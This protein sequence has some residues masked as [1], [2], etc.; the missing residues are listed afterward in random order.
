MVADICQNADV[1]GTQEDLENGDEEYK[2]ENEHKKN[3][4]R[5]YKM[6]RMSDVELQVGLSTPSDD[7]ELN[8]EDLV[9]NIENLRGEE[10]NYEK[11]E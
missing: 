2:Q 11:Q 3:R 9:P 5:P 10:E 6:K 8:A 4:R 1:T 7:G